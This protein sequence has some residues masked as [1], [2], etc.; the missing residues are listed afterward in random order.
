MKSPQAIEALDFMRRKD[1]TLVVPDVVRREVAIKLRDEL[2]LCKKQI[3]DSTRYISTILK[4]VENNA[5]PTSDDIEQGLKALFDDIGIPVRSI[6]F[7]L[8]A[9][10][11]SLDKILR[12]IQ[13]SDRVEQFIDGVIW[14]NCLHLLDESD[15]YLVSKDKAFYRNYQYSDGLAP[16]LENEISHYSN[17]LHL[18]AGLDRLLQQERREVQRV[19]PE[20]ESI[21]SQSEED[22]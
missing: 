6:Q 4:G 20:D 1:A 8:Q 7:S 12:K 19:W 16:T 9:A 15:V 5:L 13:P 22:H 17:S 14:A 10:E 18:C 2:L 21:P 11:A 3:G